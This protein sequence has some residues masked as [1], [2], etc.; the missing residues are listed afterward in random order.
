LSA[1]AST[2]RLLQERAL[3]I[4]EK[5]LGSEHPDTAQSLN[6]LAFLFHAQGDLEAARPLHERALALGSEHP[7]TAQ[8][9]NSLACS[10]HGPGRPRGGAA[11]S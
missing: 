9:L 3:A 1:V 2:A 7:D 5:T 6:G 4:R 11:A 8:S 10:D